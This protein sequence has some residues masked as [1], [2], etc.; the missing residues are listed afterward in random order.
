[1]DSNHPS[2]RRPPIQSRIAGPTSGAGNELFAI[3][4]SLGGRNVGFGVFHNA[5]PA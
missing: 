5:R 4:K 3:Y 1:M 2:L